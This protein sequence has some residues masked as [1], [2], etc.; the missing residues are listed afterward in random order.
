MRCR[1]RA[2]EA[3][4]SDPA[5]APAGEDSVGRT[6]PRTGRPAGVL[7]AA[8]GGSRLGR[9]KAVVDFHGEPLV[10]RGVR[11]LTVGGCAS[12]TVVTGAAAEQVRRVLYEDVAVVHNPQWASGMGSSLRAGIAAV[13]DAP[14]AVV[15][16]V[17]QPL[18]APD[19]VRMLIDRWRHGALI[20]AATYQGAIRHPVLFD[21]TAFPAVCHSAVG[22]QGARAL[23]RAR[24]EWVERVACEGAASPHDVDTA[25]D[26]HALL[27]EPDPNPCADHDRRKEPPWN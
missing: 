4:P 25:D 22:D 6:V 24:P 5:E 14:A 12:V 20:V 23:L 26:L 9:P 15:A 1:Q 19:A 13:C 17:D 18:V 16:L 3:V 2:P 10:R 27:A 8:G 11:L 7:L 21:A